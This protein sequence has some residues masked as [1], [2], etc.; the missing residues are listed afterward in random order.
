MSVYDLPHVTVTEKASG[1]MYL[2]VAD[3][4]WYIHCPDYEE[5]EY[6]T[7]GGFPAA[8]DFST[9]EI[10]AEADLPADAVINGDTDGDTDHEIV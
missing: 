7:A 8:Y 6:K 10:V 4:G 1:R 5:N 3:D 2:V 9:V